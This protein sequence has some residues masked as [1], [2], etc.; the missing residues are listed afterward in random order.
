MKKFVID[1]PQTEYIK[2]ADLEKLLADTFGEL[3]F[4]VTVSF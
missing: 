4:G 3:K 1:L 2:R